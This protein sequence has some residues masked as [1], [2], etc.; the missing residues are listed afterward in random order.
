MP[1]L[2][3][4]KLAKRPCAGTPLPAL[5]AAAESP[6]RCPLLCRNATPTATPLLPYL[7]LAKTECGCA[8]GCTQCLCL[9]AC[10]PAYCCNPDACQP[11][12]LP[13]LS[14]PSDASAADCL[15][16]L[17]ATDTST[18]TFALKPQPPSRRPTMV[19]RPPPGT[20]HLPLRTRCQPTN[21]P[22]YRNHGA[23]RRACWARGAARPHPPKAAWPQLEMA[24]SQ[25]ARRTAPSIVVLPPAIARAACSAGAATRAIETDEIMGG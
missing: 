16:C 20:R 8:Q 5:C 24:S 22:Y 13:L 4:W 10:L 7:R 12:F 14:M 6:T 1:F 15:A 3:A 11:C 9:P 25:P 17:G 2:V 21:R 23:P 18:D 19:S